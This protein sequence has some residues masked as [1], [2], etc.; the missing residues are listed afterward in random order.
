[1]ANSALER[2]PYFNGEARRQHGQQFGQAPTASS[3]GQQPP[4]PLTADQLNARRALQ[5]QMLTRR[6]EASPQ[7]TW[8]QDVATVLSS[9]SDEASARRLQTALKQLLRK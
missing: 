4:A 3:Y 7:Q 1:M 5:L 8:G 9:T 2:N 6:N